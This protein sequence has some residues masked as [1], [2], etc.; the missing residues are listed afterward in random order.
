MPALFNIILVSPEEDN[1]CFLS[2]HK[3]FPVPEHNEKKKKN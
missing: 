2:I 3:H 1:P